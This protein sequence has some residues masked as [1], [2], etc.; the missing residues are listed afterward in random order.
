MCE[1]IFVVGHFFKKCM[2][3][4]AWPE[5]VLGLPGATLNVYHGFPKVPCIFDSKTPTHVLVQ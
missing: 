2:F 5:I 3:P 1:V 4:E